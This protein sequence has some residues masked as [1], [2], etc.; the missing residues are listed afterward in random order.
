M[1]EFVFVIKNFHNATK[2]L[3]VNSFIIYISLKTHIFSCQLICYRYYRRA[4]KLTVTVNNIQYSH[5]VNVRGIH[6]HSKLINRTML[7]NFFKL[8][9]FCISVKVN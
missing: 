9:H 4:V 5:Y 3:A 6:D 2:Y 8:L 7:I 1:N